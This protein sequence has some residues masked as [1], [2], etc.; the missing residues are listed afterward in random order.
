MPQKLKNGG[1]TPTDYL[2]AVQAETL[3]NIKLETHEIQ[4]LEAKTTYQ[5]IK[6]TINIQL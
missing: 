6:G 1:I 3:A 4:L 5:I 2:Q